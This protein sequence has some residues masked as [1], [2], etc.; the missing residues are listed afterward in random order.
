[1]GLL[2]P[3]GD[4]ALYFTF[5]Q[6]CIFRFLTECKLLMPILSIH[7]F[8]SWSIQCFLAIPR[9]SWP[10]SSHKYHQQVFGKPPKKQTFPVS[11]PHHHI[12]TMAPMENPYKKQKVTFPEG[13]VI[14]HITNNPSCLC[15][16]CNIAQEVAQCVADFAA[17]TTEFEDPPFQGTPT[18]FLPSPP[19][20]FRTVTLAAVSSVFGSPDRASHQTTSQSQGHIFFCCMLW[21]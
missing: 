19:V 11:S 4:L 9:L 16:K 20:I 15:P 5:L 12:S 8:R 7:I 21:F 14:V 3:F 18:S 2:V 17:D 13:F 1:M 10:N 6:S